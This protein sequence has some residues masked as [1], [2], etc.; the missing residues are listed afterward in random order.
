MEANPRICAA[1]AH[2]LARRPICYAHR[3]ARAHA[4]ENTLLAFALAFDLGAEGIEC[5]VRRSKDGHLVII[6]DGTLNRT[7]N[8]VGLV[9]T[10]TFAQ[11]RALDAGRRW[12]LPQGIPTLEETLALARARG[13]ALNLEL[14]GESLEEVL[15]T[16]EAVA[17]VLDALEAPLRARVLVSSFEL[18]AVAKI[19]ALLPD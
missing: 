16:A 7:T 15:G 13:G 1:A 19:K 18:P 12:R 6:H 11:L 17:P 14:K 4:P 3:G 8:G 2:A 9:A 5:D 10:H